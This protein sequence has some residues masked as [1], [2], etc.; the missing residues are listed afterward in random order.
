MSGISEK[1]VTTIRKLWSPGGQ[2]PCSTFR[3]Y[4]KKEVSLHIEGLVDSNMNSI[5]EHWLR[6]DRTRRVKI[7]IQPL[8]PAQAANLVHDWRGDDGLMVKTSWGAAHIVYHS[9][10][11]HCRRMFGKLAR[12]WC[13]VQVHKLGSA[14]WWMWPVRICVGV[15]PFGWLGIRVNHK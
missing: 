6:L 5:R 12:F 8:L 9:I 15:H 14:V 13:Q 2:W 7:K 3:I 4:I 11:L 10:P 1:N